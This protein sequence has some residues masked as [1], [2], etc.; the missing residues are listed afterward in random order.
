MYS[1]H[2]ALALE[3][4]TYGNGGSV[5]AGSDQLLGSV[6]VAFVQLLDSPPYQAFVVLGDLQC[7]KILQEQ[8]E[9]LKKGLEYSNNM[10]KNV[11]SL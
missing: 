11:G 5:A 8:T 9:Q 4:A 10:C 1:F 2:N 6:V 3:L 7:S